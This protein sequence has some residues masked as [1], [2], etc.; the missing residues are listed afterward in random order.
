MEI[1]NSGSQNPS[2]V[3]SGLDI[4]PV[5]PASEADM[6]SLQQASYREQPYQ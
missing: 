2:K 3:L 4:M 5:I 6:G 1:W